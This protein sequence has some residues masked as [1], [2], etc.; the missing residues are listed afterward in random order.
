MYSCAVSKATVTRSAAATKSENNSPARMCFNV[1]LYW[2]RHSK[3]WRLLFVYVMLSSQLNSSAFKLVCMLTLAI[4]IVCVECKEILLAVYCIQSGHLSIKSGNISGNLTVL[5]CWTVGSY[6]RN[7]QQYLFFV[8]CVYM[9]AF[10]SFI[11]LC[12]PCSVIINEWVNNSVDV[13]FCWC[14][15]SFDMS[16]SVSS[17][18]HNHLVAI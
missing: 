3:Q 6:A 2:L 8:I 12:N 1:M 17:V 5:F 16:F 9:Y 14:Y 18:L 13:E 10:I 15:S 11:L 7:C 4:V